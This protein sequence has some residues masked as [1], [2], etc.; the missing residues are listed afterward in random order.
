MLNVKVGFIFLLLNSG[1]ICIAQNM[2]ETYSESTF[3]FFLNF[4]VYA[5]FNTPLKL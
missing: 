1:T 5:I 3:N 2:S 4:F